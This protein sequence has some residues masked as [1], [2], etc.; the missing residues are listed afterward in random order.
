[1][2][3]NSKTLL[4]PSLGPGQSQRLEEEG[5][6]R[7]LFGERNCRY[8]GGRCLRA[9]QGIWAMKGLDL[10]QH[11]RN[12]EVKQASMKHEQMN[13]NKRQMRNPGN[14]KIITK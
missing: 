3:A 10:P 2:G 8:N 13:M 11:T 9:G 1:M 5:S 6:I 12:W 7:S 4:L 14:E